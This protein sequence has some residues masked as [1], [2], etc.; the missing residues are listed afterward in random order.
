MKTFKLKAV[1][2]THQGLGVAKEYTTP[3]FVENL[4]VGE[5]AEVKITNQKKSFALGEVVGF[6]KTS[7]SRV[8][9]ICPVFFKCGG[10]QLQH[11]DY[12]EQI[13]FK[14]HKI[15]SSLQRIAKE[16]IKL[17]DF[18]FMDNPY[19]Y[20]N[21]ISLPISIDKEKIRL[22]FYQK[23]SRSIVEFKKCHL[24]DEQINEIIKTIKDVLNKYHSQFLKE[25]TKLNHLIIRK[26]FYNNEVMIVFVAKDMVFKNSRIIV[27]E[28]VGKHPEIK[29]VIQNINTSNNFEILGSKELILYGKDYL[30]DRINGL[31]FKISSRSFYQVNS[32]QTSRLYEAAIELA[33]L[34]KEDI[35]LDA[36]CGVGTIGLLLADKVNK[37]I[38]VEKEK[39]AIEDANK[40]KEINNVFNIDF[41]NED[42]KKYLVDC[43][44]DFSVVFIDPPRQGCSKEFCLQL[45]EKEPQKIIYISCEPSTLARDLL[46]FKEKYRVEKVIGVDMF[47]QTHHVETITYLSKK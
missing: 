19:F 46:L 9:P 2:Y 47:S 18:L 37:V 8:S 13:R 32:I 31:K 7:S 4:L 33:N 38:G 12:E 43:I 36:Y 40:N 6:L 17:D 21:K 29:V 45:L 14:K 28:I 42:A 11:M 20:R 16:N 35:V 44:Q 27:N 22:G 26:S 30:E 24:V 34:N 3:V 23:N 25:K 1:D 10:C 15:E 5:E 41:I 39:S